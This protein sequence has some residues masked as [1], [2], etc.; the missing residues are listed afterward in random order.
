[1]HPL[2][3]LLMTAAAL[4][5][6]K[7]W[8]DDVR[9]ARAGAENPRAFPG[10][11]PAPARAVWIAVAGALLILTGETVGEVMLGIAAQQSRMTAAA[12]LYAV[13]GAPIIE[14][15][16]FR[17]WI[18]VE[19]RGRT[20]M[21]LGAIAASG[22]FAI[23]HPFLWKWDDAGFGFQLEMKGWF[24]TATVLAMSLWLYAARL[25]E[26]NPQRSLLP[27][28]AAHAAKNLGVVAVKATA[29]FLTM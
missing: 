6:G 3:S 24:S 18:V 16:V 11:T 20:A 7:L 2:L 23:L 25:A 27:C 26:W 12:A 17:G 21:W 1:M 4:Y 5:L 13:A 10:A 14:E 22:L 9:S 8:R 28:F 15:L 29:G 19:H